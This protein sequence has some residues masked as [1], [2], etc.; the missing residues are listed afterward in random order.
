MNYCKVKAVDIANG[1]GVR[2][3]LFVAGCD[4]HC[5]GCFNTETWPFDAGKPFDE[6]AQQAVLEALEPYWVTG[7]SV[8]GGEPLDPRNLPDVAAFVAR[9]KEQLPGKDVWLYTGYT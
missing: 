9:V 7:L 2:V 4:R 3:S 1:C 8:L 6:A 5:A